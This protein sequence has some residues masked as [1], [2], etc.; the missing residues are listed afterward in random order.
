M[1]HMTAWSRAVNRSLFGR[2]TRRRWSWR[3]PEGTP[4]RPRK[5][6]NPRP[7]SPAPAAPIPAPVTPMF[8]IVNPW[9]RTKF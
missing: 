7:A 3:P 1:A 6:R 2:S 5:A 4:R 8:A 9:T